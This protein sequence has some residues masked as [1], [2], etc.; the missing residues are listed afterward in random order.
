MAEMS[1]TE[2]QQTIGGAGDMSY[3]RLLIGTEGGIWR[4]DEG[5]TYIMIGT[6]PPA[7]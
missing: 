2:M 6:P 3:G 1:T 7:N 5:I 4:G